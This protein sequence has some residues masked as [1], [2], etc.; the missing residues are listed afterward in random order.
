MPKNK[1]FQ[2]HLAPDR[3]FYAVFK[4]YTFANNYLKLYYSTFTDGSIDASE[5][6]NEIPEVES[7]KTA[8]DVL[9]FNSLCEKAD[10]FHKLYELK[11]IEAIKGTDKTR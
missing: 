2:I 7:I 3:E 9:K 1:H 8:N 11:Y 10:Y 5:L 4:L 6:K